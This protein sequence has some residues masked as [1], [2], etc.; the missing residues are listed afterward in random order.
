M[1]R[2]L[3][4]LDAHDSPTISELDCAIADQ[5]V[6]EVLHG[7]LSLEGHAAA[8]RRVGAH[9]L[10]QRD[11]VNVDRFRPLR[12]RFLFAGFRH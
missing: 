8:P 1:I 9:P 3:L 12:A 6:G 7:D 4:E 2:R 5:K 10:P 11:G